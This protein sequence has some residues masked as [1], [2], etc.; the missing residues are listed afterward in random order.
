MVIKSFKWVVIYLSLTSQV[1]A[2]T[3]YKHIVAI[4]DSVNLLINDGTLQELA[5]Y[6]LNPSDVSPIKGLLVLLPGLGT[7]PQQVF[8]ETKLA[9][10]AAHIGLITIVPSINNRLY[11]DS[12]SKQFISQAISQVVNQNPAVRRNFFIGGFSAGGHL[13]LSYAETIVANTAPND[14]I[15][16]AAFGVDPPVDM[17][18]FWQ[19]G[20]RRI[21]QNCSKLLV[22]EGQHIIASLTDLFGGSPEKFP[23]KYHDGSA[24]SSIDSLGGNAQWLKSFPIRLYAEPDLVYWRKHYCK[25]LSLDDL[26]AP[27]SA[28]MIDR[29][30]R[31]GN[32][33]AQYIETRGKG[34]VGN[35]A[36]PHSWTI[37]DVPDCIAWL[38]NL[39]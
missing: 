19:L 27:T 26:T 23:K 8:Q 4:K 2:Q 11:L 6:Q 20:Q 17:R 15:L 34:F 32:S 38:R 21:V 25:T 30:Q 16:K 9:Q 12:A 29:L 1:Y 3:V 14:L 24:F 31:L 13:A 18:E 33:R 36:F 35:R 10:Q 37:V 39:M 7:Q 22:K 28:Q 5:F